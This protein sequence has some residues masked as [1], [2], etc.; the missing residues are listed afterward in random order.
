MAAKHGS[1][2]FSKVPHPRN[3][4]NHFGANKFPPGETKCM[5]DGVERGRENG[6]AGKGEARHM[7]F[8]VKTATDTNGWP[9]KIANSVR[10]MFF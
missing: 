10:G 5:H 3:P 9:L 6:K 7:S 8:V 2:S 1:I 4:R